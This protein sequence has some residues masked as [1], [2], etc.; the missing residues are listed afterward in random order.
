[1]SAPE[2]E[3]QLFL[4]EVVGLPGSSTSMSADS[5][6]ADVD[7]REFG[8]MKQSVPKFSGKLED[9]PLWKEH[10]E[11]FTSIIV[12]CMPSFLVVPNVR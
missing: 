2:A 10:F 12:G 3:N 1:M 9:F 6:R 8:S 5:L 11:V 7:S 4:G